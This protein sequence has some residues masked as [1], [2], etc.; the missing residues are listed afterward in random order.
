MV[1][2]LHIFSAPL[3]I[4]PVPIVRTEFSSTLDG[5][6]PIYPITL[7]CP[8]DFV[9]FDDSNN[10]CCNLAA[11]NCLKVLLQGG[12]YNDSNPD[13]SLLQSKWIV[14]VTDLIITCHNSLKAS[15]SS[16][17][18][19]SQF[20]ILDSDKKSFIDIL[21][22]ALDTFYDY[23][24]DYKTDDQPWRYCLCCLEAC[25]IPLDKAAYKS[26]TMSCKQDIQAT[27]HTIVNAQL[28][29]LHKAIVRIQG[30]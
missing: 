29:D 26:V 17:L 22:Q 13:T 20:G 4:Q 7:L 18:D 28:H 19:L 24:T 12:F 30:F 2:H 10:G 16:S 25:H 6:A 8:L 1:S 3:D 14:I 9:D 21:E 5:E 27:Y 11:I 15:H 23:F